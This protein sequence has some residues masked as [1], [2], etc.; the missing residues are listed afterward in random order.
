MENLTIDF[1]LISLPG[2]LNNNRETWAKEKCDVIMSPVFE[3][4]HGDVDPQP[5]YERC[6]FDTCSCDQGGDCECLC[7]AIAVYAQVSC[8]KVESNL[9]TN[10]IGCCQ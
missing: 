4:C 10:E 1:G 9:Q 5:Y 8:G 7:T 2:C 3:A 6:I